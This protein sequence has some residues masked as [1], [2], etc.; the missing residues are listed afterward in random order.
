M[1]TSWT[2][3]HYLIQSKRKSFPLEPG[4]FWSFYG[5]KVNLP[6]YYCRIQ[7]ITLTQEFE[8]GAVVKLHVNKLKA[9]PSPENV[10]QWADKNMP[11]GCG[12]FLVMGSF[13][14]LTP[15][16]V[17]HQIVPHTSTSGSEYTILPKNGEVWAVYRSWTHRLNVFD[18]E[19]NHLDYDIVEVLDDA[20]DYKVL[21]LEAVFIDSEDEEKKTVFR[22]AERRHPGCDDEDGSEVIFTIPKSKMLRFSHQI[23]ATRIT[24]E[25]QGA[26][27]EVFEVDR[28]ALPESLN[29][30]PLSKGSKRR[31]GKDSFF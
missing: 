2:K 30:R 25:I 4:Q 18:L 7:K 3:L 1:L 20:F 15:D 10:I 21:A 14:L 23:P 6:L 13:V 8:Q 9:T 22:A 29:V 17:S 16:N 19:M 5:G 27:N 11:V 12:T 31:L 24:K 28:R 26:L